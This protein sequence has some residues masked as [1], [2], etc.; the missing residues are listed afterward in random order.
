MGYVR[1][2]TLAG[3]GLGQSSGSTAAAGVG[4][5]ISAAASLVTGAVGLAYGIGAM[6]DQRRAS[7]GYRESVWADTMG[8]INQGNLLAQQDAEVLAAQNVIAGEQESQFREQRR[9]IGEQTQALRSQIGRDRMQA[10]D[11]ARLADAMRFRLPT[12]GW[13]VIA[14]AGVAAVIGGAAFFAT[15]SAAEGT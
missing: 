9:E 10:Q 11:A 4:A 15:R 6:R 13:W 7:A 3:H 8:A 1:T 5:G 12:W 2:R 14:G